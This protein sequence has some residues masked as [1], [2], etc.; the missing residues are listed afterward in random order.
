MK[1]LNSF[2][3]VFSLFVTSAV[4]AQSDVSKLPQKPKGANPDL[5][6][7]VMGLFQRGTGFSDDRTDPPYNGF[8]MQE[9][10]LQYNADID[11]YLKGTVLL[12][13]GQE[14]GSTEYV[15]EPEEVFIES[16]SLPVVTM[17]LGKF[18]TAFGK[19]N[20]LHTHAFPLIDAPLINQELLGEEGF[21]ESGL[22][23][24]ALIPAKW[25]SELTLQAVTS[26]N[27][28][29][30]NS[31]SSSDWTGVA[32]YKNLF[33]LSDATTLEF[34]LSASL[35]RNENEKNTFLQGAD[36]TVKW[37]PSEGGKYRAII[38]TT[39]YLKGDRNGKIDA[40]SGANVE[41]LAGLST[42]LQYQIGQRWWVGGRLETLGLSA[43]SDAIEEKTKVSAIASFFPSEFSGF[44]LQYDQISVEDI[45]EQ[46]KI[47]SLQ[48]NIS[49]GAHPAHAY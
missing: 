24:S 27:E 30:F 20:P 33:D 45:D 9:T 28:E 11:P 4:F 23:V 19:H 6:I 35:G 36:V 29:S 3:I 40:V 7:V 34:G 49:M 18:K 32:R 42:V 22:S 41:D 26:T 37:R 31:T 38:W 15:I 25:F 12:A 21:N 17:K 14:E 16:I 39:E 8:S 43:S 10:E 13:I 5:S 1:W 2:S 44:R 48:F 47:V 46:D